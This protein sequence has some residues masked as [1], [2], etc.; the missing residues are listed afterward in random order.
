MRSLLL[1]CAGPLWQCFFLLRRRVRLPVPVGGV[2]FGPL[3]T[4]CLCLL[5]L[6]GA[7]FGTQSNT[8]NNQGA[9]RSR[10]PV[11]Y[12]PDHCPRPSRS[13]HEFKNRSCPAWLAYSATS[14]DNLGDRLAPPRAR[15]GEP[16]FFLLWLVALLRCFHAAPIP[17]RIFAEA[18][19]TRRCSP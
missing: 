12:S 15:L 4:A 1:A 3:R 18:R 2:D 11:F 13:V 8:C 10:V 19:H 6:R 5:A 17:G 9:S 7:C 16:L 14:R